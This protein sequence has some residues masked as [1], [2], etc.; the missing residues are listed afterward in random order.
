MTLID[1]TLKILIRWNFK[2]LLFSLLFSLCKPELGTGTLQLHSCTCANQNWFCWRTCKPRSSFLG[3]KWTVRGSSDLPCSSFLTM[4]AEQRNKEHWLDG[5]PVCSVTFGM[6]KHQG[7]K[8]MPHLQIHE[9][10]GKERVSK[11]NLFVWH[12]WRFRTVN[13]STE[14]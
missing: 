9:E 11:C 2:W 1:L 5:K 7:H 8:E 13:A 4:G 12:Y 3:S 6:K 14:T 10:M